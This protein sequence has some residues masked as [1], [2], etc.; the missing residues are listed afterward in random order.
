MA[1]VAAA[2]FGAAFLAAG[3]FAGAFFDTPPLATFF[4]GAFFVVPDGFEAEA[5][6]LAA[7]ALVPGAT[8]F[9]GGTSCLVLV[10]VAFFVAGFFA[11]LPALVYARLSRHE[12]IR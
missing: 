5:F 11:G 9:L 6:A 3:F 1:F 12:D 2:F 8:F 4:S 7:F 10:E